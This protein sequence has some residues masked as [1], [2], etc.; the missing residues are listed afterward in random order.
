MGILYRDFL[1]MA[2]GLYLLVD[3]CVLSETAKFALD[4]DAARIVR[5]GLDGVEGRAALRVGV[6]VVVVEVASAVVEPSAGGVHEPCWIQGVYEI[7]ECEL[8][9]FTIDDLAPALVVDDPGDDA[10]IA[11][12][13]TNE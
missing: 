1:V 13:L 9:V 12:V 11:A 4:G 8:G 3:G 6:V 7:G 5:S 10:W 2:W